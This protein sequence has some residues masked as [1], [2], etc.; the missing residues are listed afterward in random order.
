MDE[1]NRRRELQIAYNTEHGI[2][3]TTV[4]KSLEEILSSTSVADIQVQ[5][6]A[7]VAQMENNKRKRAAE[8]IAQYLTTEQRKEMIDQLF[9]AMKE[10]AREL[11]FERAAQLRDEIATLQALDS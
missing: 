8:P 6:V 4:Y 5:K 3:P 10:S 7:R 11:D 9:T 1:T 2:N